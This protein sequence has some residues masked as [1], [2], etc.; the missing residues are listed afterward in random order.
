[1]QCPVCRVLLE[2]SRRAGIQIDTCP[3]CRG[4]WLDRGEL[5]QIIQRSKEDEGD[6]AGAPSPPVFSPPPTPGRLAGS[7]MPG[8][9]TFPPSPAGPNDAGQPRPPG[10]R[11]PTRPRPR[12]GTIW[13]EVFD[14]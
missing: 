2:R 13:R 1:M 4:V 10:H 6:D 3:R 5:D 9:S 14:Y 7:G 11:S 8:S 12:R